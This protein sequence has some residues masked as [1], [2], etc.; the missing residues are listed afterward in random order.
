MYAWYRRRAISP[1]NCEA[2]FSARV[3]ARDAQFNHKLSA[4]DTTALTTS[5]IKESLDRVAVFSTRFLPYSQTFVFDE[6]LHHHRYRAEVFCLER[7]NEALFPF[8]DV[9]ALL[10]AEGIL[11]KVRA[12]LYRYFLYS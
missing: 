12:D 2:A 10:P 9:H 7:M 11:G 1:A 5:S 4:M 8:P 3:H 6:L